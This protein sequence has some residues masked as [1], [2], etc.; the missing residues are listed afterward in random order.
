MSEQHDIAEIQAAVTRLQQLD[1]LVLATVGQDGVPLASYAPFAEHDGCLY[2]LLSGL[3]LHTQNLQRQ[4]QANVMLIED[5]ASA[6]NIFARARLNYT[7]SV[8][9]IEK[10]TT[11]GIAALQTMK[12]KLGKT[13]DVLGELPDFMLFR[14]QL[15]KARLVTGFGRAY[16][17]MPGDVAGAVQL[18][19]KNAKTE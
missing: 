4:Q 19:E 3:S 17:F 15:E 18:T 9:T 12:A 11:D 14:L 1:S 7:V 5:E 2:V 10:D 13:V 16:V 6:R 8:T